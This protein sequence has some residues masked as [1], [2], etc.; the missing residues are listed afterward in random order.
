MK[1]IR[2]KEFR[3]GITVECD[4]FLLA[5]GRLDRVQELLRVLAPG[6]STGLHMW[7]HGEPKKPVDVSVPGSLAKA[8]EA[9]ATERGPFFAELEKRFGAVNS[10][11]T[12]GGAELRGA[13]KSLTLVVEVDSEIFQRIGEAWIWG[14]SISLQVCRAK[15][16]G[17]DA[18]S[19]S[20]KALERFCS[21][22]SPAW[23]HAEM[24]EEYETKNI[25]REGGGMR[26]VGVD[27][28]RAL[29]GL[30]WLNFYGSTCRD[31]IGRE[32]LLTASAA[33]VREVDNGVLLMLHPD[34]TAWDTPEYK[35]T[36]RHM[37][38]HLG[39]EYF[40]SKEAPD[41]QTVPPV[42]GLPLLPPAQPVG[43]PEKLQDQP[44]VWWRLWR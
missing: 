11:R 25:S 8:V 1:T 42:E 37:L 44:G 33:Q 23:A 16:E 17:I 13:D 38:D 43:E 18:A 3:V 26:A 14:N 39:P 7:L 15:V 27:I 36:E 5:E 40:F 30:Y 29:P 12:L 34:P 28:S 31:R 6:W 9:A 20:A 24:G 35:A 4:G 2:P 32:R 22:L 21:A 41:R 19:W 10:T